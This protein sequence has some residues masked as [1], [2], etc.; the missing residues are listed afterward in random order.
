M[1]T[2]V[3]YKL[4]LH[5]DFKDKFTKYYRPDVNKNNKVLFDKHL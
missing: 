4:R 2:I 5:N 3:F 1:Q